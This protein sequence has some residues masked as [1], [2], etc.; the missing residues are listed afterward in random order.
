M[1]WGWH[2]V[3]ANGESER[4]VLDDLIFELFHHG[5]RD[6]Y[7]NWLRITGSR[8][9]EFA[10]QGHAWNVHKPRGTSL[11]YK[12]L[13]DGHWIWRPLLLATS[14]N[15]WRSVEML[16]KVGHS[17]NEYSKGN[18]SAM[19][20]GAQAG[21]IK[22]MEVLLEVGK[23]NINIRDWNGATPLHSCCDSQDPVNVGAKT[24]LWLRKRGASDMYAT[25]SAGGPLH[26]AAY[27]GLTPLV[28]AYMKSGTD[29]NMWCDHHH[30]ETVWLATAL[31]CAAYSGNVE[32]VQLL[33][34]NR[35]N[36]NDIKGKMKTALHAAAVGGHPSTV[37]FLL[38]KGARIPEVVGQYGSILSAAV[39]SGNKE[40][41]ELFLELGLSWGDFVDESLESVKD[42][43]WGSLDQAKRS[44]LISWIIDLSA[45]WYCSNIIEA[46]RR[47]LVQRVK[48]FLANGADRDAVEHVHMRPPIN[49]AACN[50]HVE[51][52]KV[53]AQ[54][55]ANL[56][57]PNRNGETPLEA[58]CRTNHLDV[59]KTLLA[60]GADPNLQ[61]VG[62]FTAPLLSANMS[63]DPAM[64]Q[65]VRGL[66]SLRIEERTFKWEGHMYRHDSKANRY[67]KDD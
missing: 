13:L 64:I 21:A 25:S 34:E 1:N 60:L 37:R 26:A 29:P 33:L 10:V 30:D 9:P 53:L 39:Y 54:A 23:A 58:A 16:L 27:R 47:G 35:A 51:V 14:W 24:V 7:V 59:V 31:Q 38:A 50:G 11:S 2:A 15:L 62:K 32:C 17:A 36:L 49:W 43:E 8:G 52:V 66:A 46:A 48:A 67:V 40:I 45:E 5:S 3:E 19:Q 4:G 41:V 6:A 12:E 22:A 42:Q 57:G 20:R 61:P 63:G 55:G 65:F 28:S 18:I 44:H 56:N